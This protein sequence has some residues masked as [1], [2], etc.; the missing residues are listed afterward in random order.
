MHGHSARVSK[1]LVVCAGLLVLSVAVAAQ[2]GGNN[3][4]STLKGVTVPQPDLTQYV[5]RQDVLLILGKALFWDVQV[6][7]DGRTA[8]ASC[9]FHAGADHR[10]TNQLSGPFTSSAAVL[11]NLT[12]TA[13]DFPFH[14]FANPN[15][16][17]SA[18]IRA[19]RDVVDPPVCCCSDSS[20]SRRAPLPTLVLMP[21]WGPVH[22]WWLEGAASDGAQYAECDQCRA[23][24]AEFLGRPRE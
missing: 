10:T 20:R 23:Q 8:C 7:S 22:R 3:A 11:A 18:V 15:D 16:N 21:G 14:V 13:A 1:L 5:A 2:R 24:R 17:E 9:H 4:I 19:R 12:L 6:G